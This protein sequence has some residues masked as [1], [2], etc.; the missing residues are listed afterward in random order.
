LPSEVLAGRLKVSFLRPDAIADFPAELQALL[1]G[2]RSS[3]WSAATFAVNSHHVVIENT[4]H[5]QNRRE[6]TRMHEM[7]HVICGHRPTGIRV[8]KEV[9]VLLRGHDQEQEDEADWLGRCL[10]L[11]KPLLGWCLNRNFTPEQISAH[12]RASLELVRLRLNLSGVLLIRR[13]MN[14][15]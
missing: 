9:G 12:C 6:A 13:R 8:V 14:R 1:L 5:S 7:S 3:E 15:G 2:Q 10:Q 4:V 11:P